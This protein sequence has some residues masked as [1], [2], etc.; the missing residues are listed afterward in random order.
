MNSRKLSITELEEISKRLL[1]ANEMVRRLCLRRDDPESREWIMSI[2]AQPDRDPDLVI[3]AALADITKL[4][5]ALAQHAQPELT[6]EEFE[7]FAATQHPDPH[8]KQW[9][10]VGWNGAKWARDKAT[11]TRI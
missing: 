5:H 10:R 4:A 1:A 6:P 8:E 2:P 9:M 11:E 3:S 7:Q